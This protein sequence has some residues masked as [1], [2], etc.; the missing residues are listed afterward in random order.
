MAGDMP[1]SNATWTC[2]QCGHAVQRPLGRAPVFDQVRD[3]ACSRCGAKGLVVIELGSRSYGTT[4]AFTALEARR[5]KP[6][7]RG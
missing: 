7:A 1:E 6:S 4:E 5:G 2:S 3:A